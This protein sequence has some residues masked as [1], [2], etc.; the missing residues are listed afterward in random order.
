MIRK[1]IEELYLNIDYTWTDLEVVNYI[2]SILIFVPE[3]DY[4]YNI[5]LLAGLKAEMREKK[6]KIIL[7]KD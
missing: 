3:E 2:E 7:K 1:E 5:E 6:I 4:D